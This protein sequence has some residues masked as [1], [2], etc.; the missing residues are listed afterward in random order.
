MI[1]F[2][3]KIRHSI[4]SK[5]IHFV[6]LTTFVFSLI[7]PP[8]YAQSI[9]VTSTPLQL[10]AT[11]LNLPGSGI[12]IKGI[13]VYPENP[14]H[15]DF[16]IDPQKSGFSEDQLKIESE[17]LIKYFLAGVTVP[18]D[19][20]WV[21]LSPAEKDRIVPKSFGITEMGRDLLAEDYILKQI[22][23]SLMSPEGETGKRL[24]DKIY[25]KVYE[26]YGPTAKSWKSC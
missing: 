10:S 16:I 17:K 24:W 5:V 15:L 3:R 2:Q 22:T 4:L 25:E 11:P 18:E 7:T 8:A 13:K 6:I 14:L 20:M 19:D 12:S 1:A 21:N 26:K 9:A 23:S